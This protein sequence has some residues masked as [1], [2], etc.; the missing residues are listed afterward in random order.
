LC[1]SGIYPCE[2]RV[3]LIGAASDVSPAAAW[4]SVRSAAIRGL[5]G[6]GRAL[7]GKGR[8]SGDY[9]QLFEALAGGK[10]DSGIPERRRLP[11]ACVYL[12]C[13]WPGRRTGRYP[14]VRLSGRGKRVSLDDGAC[15][16]GRRTGSGGIRTD[17][18]DLHRKPLPSV[19][20]EKNLCAK[21]VKFQRASGGQFLPVILQLSSEI[22]AIVNP[23]AAILFCTDWRLFH[24]LVKRSVIRCRFS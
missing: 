3:V 20:Y 12:P 18:R 13:I 8:R 23:T 6:A 19:P 15:G 7:T 10:K 11:D 24:M 4:D 22:A 21:P 5:G 9:V 2:K 1:A 14:A 16:V 17:G